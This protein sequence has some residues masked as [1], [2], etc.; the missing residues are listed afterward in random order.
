[1]S[2][3]QRLLWAALPALL[4]WPG[5]AR[6]DTGPERPVVR[7]GSK[8]FTEGVLLGEMLCHLV[9]DGGGVPVHLSWLGDTGKVWNGLLD[10]GIDVYGEYTGTLFKEILSDEHLRET[11][12]AL[13][14][15][16]AKRGLRMS[17]PLGFKNNYALG[18]RAD[19]AEE[20]KITKISD[21]NKHPEL[22]LG[23]SNPFLPRSDGWAG[24]KNHYGLKFADPRGLDHALVYQALE[25]GTLDVTDLYT[26]DAQIVPKKLRVL[27]DDL[28]FFTAYQAVILYRADLEERAPK[29]VASLRR[30]EGTISDAEMTALNTRVEVEDVHESKVAAD[31]LA[32]KLGVQVEPR[33]PT[34]AEN[35][36]TWTGQHLLLVAV[37]LTLA[38]AIAVPL[39][40]LAARIRWL[41][42]VILGIVGVVQ[43][44]PALALLFLISVLLHMLGVVPATV[45]LF[46][47]SLLPIVR[48]TYTGLTD[49]PLP[50]R[51]SAEALGLSGWARLRL[52]E[53]PLAARAILAG[54]K[55]SAVIN[56]G[57]ATLGGLIAAGGYGQPI[58]MGLNKSNLGL[59]L[60]GAIPAVLMALAAHL[61]FEWVERLVV[62]KGLR[63]QAA[64]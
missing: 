52:I 17:K 6:A 1:M 39:G 2:Y 37:S 12:D 58:I 59:I 36:L 64:Q 47:Y 56:I 54:I 44:V 25:N 35:L 22:K 62:S 23:F 26:T 33:V 63:L 45:A 9:T 49:I 24:L 30:L 10:G 55:T 28:H 20:L 4:L 53:L 43:T 41:G 29:V 61:L 7:V 42:H 51:E 32:Q 34:M 27:E 48:N 21:L 60:Q 8:A 46:C 31:F 18:M 57:N 38:I 50:L 19:R 3:R 40:V 11:D 13:R 5:P 14:R 16:L 15:A